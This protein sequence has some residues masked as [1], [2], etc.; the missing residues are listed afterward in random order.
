MGAGESPALMTEEFGLEQV[1]GNRRAVHRNKRQRRPSSIG[2]NCTGNPLLAGACFP[3]DKDRRGQVGHPGNPLVHVDHARRGPDQDVVSVPRGITGRDLRLHGCRCM[4]QY[5]REHCGNFLRCTGLCQVLVSPGVES[6]DNGFN[7]GPCAHYDD[8]NI[9]AH[10][11]QR[12]DCIEGVHIGQ[13]DI[14]NDAVRRSLANQR[15]HLSAR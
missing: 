4:L 15:Q 12:P 10:R 2:V 9:V 7:I 3:R 14:H 8:P 5:P 13:N 6:S 11:M 1:F